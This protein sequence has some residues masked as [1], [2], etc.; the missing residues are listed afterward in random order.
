MIHIVCA[1]YQEAHFLITH[2]QLKKRNDFHRLQVFENTERGLRV[3]VTGVGM[4]R[5]AMAVSIATERLKVAEHDLLWNIGSCAASFEASPGTVFLCNKLIEEPTGC[6]FYPDILYRHP[7]K[8][9]AVVSRMTPMTGEPEPGLLYDM[10]AS[11][12]YQAGISDY[13]PH[14]MLFIKVVSDYG[15]GTP[16]ATALQCLMDEAGETMLPFLERFL[17][18]HAGQE[19]SA[20]GQTE[21]EWEQRLV[22]DLHCSVTMEHEL[23]QLLRYCALADRNVRDEL[24]RDYGQGVL[25][26]RSKR[27]GKQYLEKLKAGLF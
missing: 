8:E 22:R 17:S 16:D 26:C 6:T 4:L 5:A 19:Q 20:N 25:P 18:F 27:E 10:E 13:G 23:M 9:R 14:R 3:L 1:L 21:E 24:E 12:V 15:K 2:Y 11:G 7:F